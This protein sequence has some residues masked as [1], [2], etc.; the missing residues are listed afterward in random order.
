MN[1]SSHQNSRD[2]F[3]TARA[4]H[5]GADQELVKKF[6]EL[7]ELLEK[8]EKSSGNSVGAVQRSLDQ[9]DVCRRDILI[10]AFGGTIRSELLRAFLDACGD[11]P[12]TSA[13]SGPKAVERITDAELIALVGRLFRQFVSI[14]EAVVGIA[15]EFTKDATKA[16]LPGKRVDLKSYTLQLLRSGGTDSAQQINDYLEDI[17]RW[18][19]AILAAWANAPEEWWKEWWGRI[20]PRTIESKPRAGLLAKLLANKHRQW[21]DEFRELVRDLNPD[22]V[23]SQ[24]WE[25]AAK[26]AIDRFRNRNQEGAG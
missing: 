19:A 26:L 7:A 22:E 13:N 24:L 16:R 21:W 25:V 5:A 10:R 12:V 3:G 17:S 11:H 6:S 2:T 1:S 23:R 15:A 4:P 20:N 14:E 8:T 18:T 9:L